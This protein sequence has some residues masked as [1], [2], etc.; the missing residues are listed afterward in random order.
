LVHGRLES[1]RG[2]L[3]HEGQRLDP[4]HAERPAP[5]LSGRPARRVRHR[6]VPRRRR[7]S[8]RRCSI[9]SPVALSDRRGA[10]LP[11]GLGRVG[12]F[13]ACP[14]TSTGSGCEAPAHHP[15][16]ATL[17]GGRMAPGRKLRSRSASAAR[18]AR[19]WRQQRRR[20]PCLLLFDLAD[21]TGGMK[22]LRRGLG[23]DA[24]AQP[25]RIFGEVSG[26]LRYCARRHAPGGTRG[27][28]T[29]RP[30]AR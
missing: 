3:R 22:A 5:R 21:A 19:A 12:M 30:S 20:V 28:S 11:R 26:R 24:R 27:L 25:L 6:T 16:D 4:L 9:L 17:G 23:D 13:G 18:R 15:L 1:R 14:S 7:R 10:Y 29:R 2:A 8:D